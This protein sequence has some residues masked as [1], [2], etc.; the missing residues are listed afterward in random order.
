M[1][2]HVLALRHGE[3]IVKPV[4]DHA[5]GTFGQPETVEPKPIV[6]IRGLFPLLS[7]RL[8]SAFDVKV[9]LD[10]DEELKYHWKVQ[11]DVAQRGY[12]L[13]EVIRQI[14]ERQDDVRAYI[15]PQRMY[16]DRVVRFYPPG[17]YLR[18][19]SGLARAPV[20]SRK[21]SPRRGFRRHRSDPGRR[22][23]TW[24]DTGHDR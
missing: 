13:E 17:G 24:A 9:W 1:E 20:W 6:I 19:R 3:T 5:T 23:R 11:R 8:R 14:V 12:V 21:P 15:L 22:T 16:A 2:E 7:E 10:P 18:A 4:Y